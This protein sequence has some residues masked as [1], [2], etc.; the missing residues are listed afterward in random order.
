VLSALTIAEK[1]RSYRRQQSAIERL[2]AELT[3]LATEIRDLLRK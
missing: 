2:L 3:A 1:V